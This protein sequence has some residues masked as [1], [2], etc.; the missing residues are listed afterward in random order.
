[1]L[2]SSTPEESLPKLERRT[3]DIPDEIR[4]AGTGKAEILHFD[5]VSLMRF[6]L[7]VGW[8]WSRH[9]KPLARTT[10]C[11][12]MHV[13]YMVSGWLHVAMD[14]GTEMDFG[15]GDV[16]VIAPGHDAWVVGS[17]PVISVDATASSEWGND[18]RLTPHSNT[19]RT[20]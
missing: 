11:Q 9:V 5:T 12:A 6:T 15:P 16:A 4:Q 2:F 1:M 13:S 18:G 19:A 8:R 20:R 3:F 7:P 17:Y 10:S 14:D